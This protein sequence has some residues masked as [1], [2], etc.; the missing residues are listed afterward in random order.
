MTDRDQRHEATLLKRAP[1]APVIASLFALLLLVFG[2]D[3]FGRLHT[4]PFGSAS[5]SRADHGKVA[6]GVSETRHLSP[7][8]HSSRLK[9]RPGVD[10]DGCLAPD[11]KT[12]WMCR[13]GKLVWRPLA[14]RMVFQLA[15]AYRSRAPPTLQHA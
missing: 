6:A 14:D 4:A 10:G 15:L 12:L 5:L 9:L 11:I 13:N 3:V 2:G 8:D 1:L 7:V